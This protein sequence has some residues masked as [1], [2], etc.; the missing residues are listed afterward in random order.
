MAIEW[1]Y[2]GRI[3]N[4]AENQIDPAIDRRES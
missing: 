1:K 4:L 3:F 2:R